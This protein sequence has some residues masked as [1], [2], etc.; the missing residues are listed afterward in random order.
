ML[1]VSFLCSIFES[2]LLTVTRPQIEVLVR[3]GRRAGPLLADFK[4][5]MDVTDRGDSHPEYGRTYYRCGRSRCELHRCFQRKHTLAVLDSV[6]D[7]CTLVYRDNSEDAR[8][9]PR[10]GV[11]T[12]GPRMEF[13][14]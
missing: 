4:E 1:V 3:E 12:A 9:F 6:Y 14:G 10:T 11:S 2:V 13:A 7:R 5:N 8:R